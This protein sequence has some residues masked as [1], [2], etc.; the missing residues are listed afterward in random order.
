MLSNRSWPHASLAKYDAYS[1]SVHCSMM[2]F[3]CHLRS[4]NRSLV[5]SRSPMLCY[6]TIPS[7]RSTGSN[8]TMQKSLHHRHPNYW[9]SQHYYCSTHVAAF[10][11]LV[12]WHRYR[13][14]CRCHHRYRYYFWLHRSSSNCPSRRPF[15]KFQIQ[16]DARIVLLCRMEYHRIVTHCF[17]FVLN[18]RRH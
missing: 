1:L 9:H 16:C 3:R 6:R 14:H 5:S 10:Q 7:K 17:H 12:V 15:A 2:N 4:C 13:L 8:C 11:L 18:L